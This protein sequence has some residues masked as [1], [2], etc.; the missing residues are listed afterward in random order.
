M[1]YAL[2]V[3]SVPLGELQRIVGSS[4]DDMV[5]EIAE[6]EASTIE[7]FD[8]I[9]ED[10][11]DRVPC[12]EAIRH[13]VHGGP[14]TG[15]SSLY[16]FA[17]EAICGHIGSFVNNRAFQPP[18]RW[19]WIT[20]VDEFLASLKFPLRVADLCCV[21]P[22]LGVPVDNMGFWPR[23]H[24]EKALHFLENYQPNGLDTDL[25]EALASIIGWLAEALHHEDDVLIGIYS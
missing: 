20:R 10:D 8:H 16:T 24:F 14:Y 19:G 1:S 9:F 5:A 25:A 6:E 7:E 11:E 22:P 18:I 12:L 21:S 17:L 4:D 3:Y 13:I 2:V 15:G 23:D